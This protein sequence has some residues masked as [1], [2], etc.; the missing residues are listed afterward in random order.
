M[1]RETSCAS[2]K[3]EARR[4]S[5]GLEGEHEVPQEEAFHPA[6]LP[7]PL[8]NQLYA[9]VLSWLHFFFLMLFIAA[10]KLRLDWYRQLLIQKPCAGWTK[11]PEDD[12]LERPLGVCQISTC[13]THAGCLCL[14]HS[15]S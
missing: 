5:Y 4:A 9:Q 10:R 3:Q 13:I 15:L 7:S 14:G 2:L 6:P 1:T 11:A 8:T 12:A